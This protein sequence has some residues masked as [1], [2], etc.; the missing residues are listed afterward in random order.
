MRNANLRI[1]ARRKRLETEGRSPTR[2]ISRLAIY[3]KRKVPKLTS[4]SS[5][6]ILLVG[7]KVLEENGGVEDKVATSA[8]GSEANEQSQNNPIGRGAS[9][10]S[11]Y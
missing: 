2:L 10:D 5:H 6:E 8:K 4:K 9:D 7:G 11:H 1:E 3:F